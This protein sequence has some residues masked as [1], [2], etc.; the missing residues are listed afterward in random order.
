R[1]SSDA[2]RDRLVSR[3]APRGGDARVQPL[4]KRRAPG[5][6]STPDPHPRC[7]APGTDAHLIMSRIKSAMALVIAALLVAGC[8]LD[9]STPSGW[10]TRGP[11]SSAGLPASDEAA[12]AKEQMGVAEGS[13][14][15]KSDLSH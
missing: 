3:L 10:Q 4:R 14:S 12:P 1:P 2:S 7:P 11:R 6:T 13:A 9:T 15:H 5:S 8:K